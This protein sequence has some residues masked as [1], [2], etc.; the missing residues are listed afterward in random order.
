MKACDLHALS[1]CSGMQLGRLIT[2]CE[3][4]S[5]SLFMNRIMYFIQILAAKEYYFGNFPRAVFS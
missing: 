3:V 1:V 2:S 5:T 4:I